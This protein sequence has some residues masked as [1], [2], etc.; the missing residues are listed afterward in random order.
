MLTGF[1]EAETWSGP[2]RNSGLATV[3]NRQWA[4][5]R[6]GSP[7]G[8]RAGVAGNGRAAITLTSWRVRT[9]RQGPLRGLPID[10]QCSCGR[11]LSSWHRPGL[12][13]C[14]GPVCSLSRRSR[15]WSMPS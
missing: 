9:R 14:S 5:A 1:G 13:C 6:H 12:A 7:H 4:G 2:P 11:S 10:L 3:S 15:L 8:H